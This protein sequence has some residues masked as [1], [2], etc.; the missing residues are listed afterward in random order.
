M[1]SPPGRGSQRWEHSTLGKQPIQVRQGAVAADEEAQAFGVSLTRPLARPR[2]APRIIRI[3]ADA[4]QG[5]AAA[6]RATLDSA[7]VKVLAAERHAAIGTGVA[8][9]RASLPGGGGLLAR[10]AVTAHFRK[11]F[12]LI[13]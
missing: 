1:P 13:M 8:D 4:A 10:T 5:L 6:M 11:A 12:D 7:A 9:H 2:F 3:E